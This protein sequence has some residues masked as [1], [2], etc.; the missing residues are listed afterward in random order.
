MDGFGVGQLVQ[1]L[2]A[3]LRDPAPWLGLGAP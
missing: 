1:A 3:R 2:E